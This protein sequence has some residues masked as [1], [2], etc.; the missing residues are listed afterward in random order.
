VRD[1]LGYGSANDFEGPPALTLSNTQSATRTPP[2]TD[3][4]NN[5]ADFARVA[6]TPENSGGGGGGCGYTGTLIRAIQGSTHLSPLNGTFVS[7]VRGVV[8]AVRSNGFYFQ[9]PC[10]DGSTATSEALFVFTSS[11]PTVSVGQEVAV[12]GTVS[13]FRSGG[14][15]STNLTTTEITGPSITVV[16]SRALPA[17][18][19][20]GSGG[21]VPPGRGYDVVHVNA[22]F[23]TQLSDHDPQ[24]ARLTP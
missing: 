16:G 17:P 21:R 8:T 24:V 10:P 3:T 12:A 2:T 23:A 15:G 4:D 9:D 6:P 11:A 14:A 19:V 5:A 20:V 22:E 18:V 7:N 13:E 1:F